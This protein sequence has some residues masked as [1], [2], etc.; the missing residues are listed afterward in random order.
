[1]SIVRKSFG[2]YFTNCRGYL[3]NAFK[4]D[5]LN[6]YYKK[7]LRSFYCNQKSFLYECTQQYSLKLPLRENP[8]EHISQVKGYFF[9]CTRWCFLRLPLS[10]KPLEH[11]SQIK[12]FFLHVQNGGF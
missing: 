7:I 8:L 11:I 6:T 9:M 1:M 5:I 12:G 3:L 4:N 10:E 2:T